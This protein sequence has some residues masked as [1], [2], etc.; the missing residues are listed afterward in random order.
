MTVAKGDAGMAFLLTATAGL[1][2]VLGACMVFFAK[3]AN[4][5]TLAVS[6]GLAA[7][8]MLFISFYDLLALASIRA[9]SDGGLEDKF[10]QLYAMLSFFGGVIF[11]HI[12]DWILHGLADCTAGEKRPGGVPS[13][14]AAHGHGTSLPSWMLPDDEKA[15]ILQAVPT[16]P[17]AEQPEVAEHGGMDV[18]SGQCPQPATAT[19]RH[20]PQ[21]N[22]RASTSPP[23]TTTLFLTSPP[24]GSLEHA[25]GTTTERASSTATAPA[26]AAPQVPDKQG[27]ARLLRTG[28]LTAVVIGIHNFPEGIATFVSSLKDVKLGAS[29][30]IA[31]ALHNIP[32]G[33]CVS[34][35]V[36]YATGSKKKAFFWAFLSGM[37]EPLGALLAYIVLANVMNNVAFGILF[38]GVAGVMVSIVLVE[39]L[40][41]ARKYDPEDKYVSTSLFVGMAVM[42]ASLILFKF[43]S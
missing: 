30:C 11:L 22:K 29:M 8:V 28:L 1:A 10:A 32:E 16:L 39:L 15:A 41:A 34:M 3:L 42:S 33:I 36:F 9:F 35:P 26:A 12:I 24:A 6:L 21:S 4:R 5:G 40:P 18:E 25:A 37:A 23:S 2:T 13:L 17:C 38:G 7:G 20:L 27:R 19:G 31:I 43:S 14:S